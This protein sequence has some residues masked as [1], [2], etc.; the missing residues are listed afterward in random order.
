MPEGG[1]LL[2][3]TVHQQMYLTSDSNRNIVYIKL[4]A[5][6]ILVVGFTAAFAISAY[7][8]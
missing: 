1:K 2:G 6:I 7:H 4:G 5:V 3:L 8:H